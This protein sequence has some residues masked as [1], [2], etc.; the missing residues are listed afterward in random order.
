M[1]RTTSPS[2]ITLAL[3][4]A[5]AASACGKHEA[6]AADPAAAGAPATAIGSAGFAAYTVPAG[7]AAGGN[8]SLDAVNGATPAAGTA[9]ATVAG[10]TVFSGWMSD[11]GGQV[12][13][14]ALLVLTGADGAYAANLV[15]GGERPDV[16]AALGNDNLRTS[17]FNL[18]THLAAAEPGSYVL[19]IVHGGASP[20]ACPL[21][22]T[23]TVSAG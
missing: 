20:L 9:A 12:P 7:L 11:A 2:S 16:A 8:C 13:T 10:E 19:S 4:I 18:S 22:V 14:D 5:I 6:P 3:I 17:G 15:G 1:R 23:L 21:N